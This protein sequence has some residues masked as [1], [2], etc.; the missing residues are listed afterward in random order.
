MNLEKSTKSRF[1]IVS[2]W[3]AFNLLDA[4]TTYIGIRNGNREFNPIYHRLMTQFGLL[5]ALVVKMII[6]IVIVTILLTCRRE[7][8]WKVLRISNV[9]IC[10]SV[11]W[12]IRIIIGR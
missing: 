10:G 9:V 8:T 11:L 3:L 5:P 1:Y 12:N 4:I 6:A 7:K 2:L